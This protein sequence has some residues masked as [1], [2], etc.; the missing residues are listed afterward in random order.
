MKNKILGNR[1]EREV[2]DIFHKKGYWVH[3][4]NSGK[5]G[6]PVDLI[7]CK[8]GYCRLIEVKHCST[9]RFYLERIED[10]QLLSLR[11]FNTINQSSSGL[12]I[13]VRE[14][15][16]FISYENILILLKKQLKYIDYKMIKFIGDRLD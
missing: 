7:V 10:N 11:K 2:V 15:F 9:D 16:Y 6:Q 3:N 5:S 12:V 1:T 13:K 8:D 14:E 4:F